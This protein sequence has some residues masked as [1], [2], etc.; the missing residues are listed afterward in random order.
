M[1]AFHDVRFPLALGLGASGGPER[2]NEI[3]TLTSGREKRNQRQIHARRRYDAGTGIR[4]LA[5]LET[6]M[7]FFEARRGSLHAF[8][9]RDPFDWKSCPASASV[10]ATD[11]VI[12]TGDGQTTSF[13]LTK[14]YGSGPDAYVRPVTKPVMATIRM[15]LDGVNL[16]AG[17]AFSVDGLTGIVTLADAPA[18]GLFRLSVSQAGSLAGSALPASRILSFP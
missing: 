5:D 1:T 15:A 6:L 8:R 14:T 4:S 18:Q 9:F 17:S 12:A 7:A 2:R 10:T 16:P 13:Q 3:V 11:Q